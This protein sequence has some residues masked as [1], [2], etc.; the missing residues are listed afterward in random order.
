VRIFIVVAKHRPDLYQY[1]AAG[2]DG[3]A[4]VNVI[5]DRRLGPDDPP[6]QLDDMPPH[7]RRTPRDVYDELAQRGFVIVRLPT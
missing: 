3:V 1:F 6:S 4:D 2:F 5:L 7:E